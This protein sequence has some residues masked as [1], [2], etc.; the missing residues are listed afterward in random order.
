MISMPFKKVCYAPKDLHALTVGIKRT[1]S[2]VPVATLRSIQIVQI[3][4]V[5]ESQ[6]NADDFADYCDPDAD[7][8]RSGLAAQP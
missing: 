2:G 8:R 5:V 6:S 7:R 1:F 3:D 4:V